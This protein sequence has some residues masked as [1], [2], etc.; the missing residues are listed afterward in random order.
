MH[1][2]RVAEVHDGVHANAT[3]R[4]G[5]AAS[6][7]RLAGIADVV[8]ADR[9]AHRRSATGGFRADLGLDDVGVVGGERGRASGGH[10]GAGADMHARV[11]LGDGNCHG[12]ADAG[13]ALGAV[14]GFGAGAMRAHRVDSDTARVASDVGAIQ[15]IGSG[16]VEDE[17]E[18]ERRAHPHTAAH[19]AVTGGQSL[20]GVVGGGLCAH[21]DRTDGRE[22]IT[23]IGQRHVAR[24]LGVGDDGGSV[25]RYRA[26]HANVAAAGARGGTGED[27]VRALRQRVVVADIVARELDRGAVE[28]VLARRGQLGMRVIEHDDE[29]GGAISQAADGGAPARVVHHLVTGSQRVVGAQ[30]EHPQ[31]VR[32]GVELHRRERVLLFADQRHVDELAELVRV[33]GGSASEVDQTGCA[34]SLGI[35][36]VRAV[37]LDLAAAFVVNPVARAVG[38]AAYA[39][40]STVVVLHLLPVGQAVFGAQ[41]DGIGRH[42]D[43]GDLRGL[44]LDTA[45]EHERLDH[46][47]VGRGHGA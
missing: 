10:G 4:S 8:D 3:A 29:V 15:H 44:E 27:A 34:A 1:V 14:P 6:N 30:V 18:R 24:H 13:I 23:P 43:D 11:A 25:D 22:R 5:Q 32:I 37:E 40:S 9:S 19:A 20:G 17:V 39:G 21:R 28:R 31:V 26:G 12:S 7:L 46:H 41:E 45:V 2:E 47:A 16:V 36:L 38:Q 42:V 33:A 35:G